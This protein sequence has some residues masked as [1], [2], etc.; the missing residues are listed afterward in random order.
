VIIAFHV[1]GDTVTID[2]ILY[3]GRDIG[4]ELGDG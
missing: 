4:A 2:R 3:A 1:A